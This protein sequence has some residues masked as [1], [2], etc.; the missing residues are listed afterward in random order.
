MTGVTSRNTPGT[1]GITA[2]SEIDRIRVVIVERDV[3]PQHAFA[4]NGDEYVGE[5]N[6]NPEFPL[7]FDGAL[8]LA[9]RIENGTAS[10]EFQTPYGTFAEADTPW[11]AREFVH[12]RNPFLRRPAPVPTTVESRRT[13]VEAWGREA[14]QPRRFMQSLI[15]ELEYPSRPN[16]ARAVI[17]HY[18]VMMNLAAAQTDDW[19]EDADVWPAIERNIELDTETFLLQCAEAVWT[20]PSGYMEALSRIYK[21]GEY[22]TSAPVHI[23]TN[24]PAL[25]RLHAGAAR[26]K[27]IIYG[28]E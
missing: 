26:A 24:P 3:H 20:E 1:R 16:R 10:L 21:A 6:W 15:N 22:L 11:Y 14:T 8:E 13:Q 7:W 23:V 27:A 18:F 2:E 5:V 9:K 19:L 12:A 28:G 4:Y 17:W 25:S